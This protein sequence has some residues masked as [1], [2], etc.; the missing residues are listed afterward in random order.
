MSRKPRMFI[1]GGMYLVTG[2]T[3]HGRYLLHPAS[4]IRELIGGV[5]ARA[6]HRYRDVRLY[7][8]VFM[9]NHFHIIVSAPPE[10]LSAFMAYIQSNIARKVG[11]LVGWRQKFWAHRFRAQEILDEEALERLMAYVWAHGAKEGLVDEGKHWPGLHCIGELLT[12]K[13]RHFPWVDRTARYKAMRKKK[14]K[15]LPDSDFTTFYP[16]RLSPLP[17]LAKHG[18]TERRKA[19]KSLYKEA[20]ELAEKKREGKAP[21]GVEAV[22]AQDPHDKPKVFKAKPQPICHSSCS[23]RRMRYR[24]SYAEFTAHYRHAS[25]RLRS[26]SAADFPAFAFRPPLPFNWEAKAQAPPPT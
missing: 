4:R 23:K 2:R 22:L 26:G 3:I 17:H 20:C 15:H 21:L 9:S 16:L 8:L 6:Q 7:N 19:Y 18:E 12:G 10:Q 5:L 25:A 14:R 11:A 13:E 1:P 24:E